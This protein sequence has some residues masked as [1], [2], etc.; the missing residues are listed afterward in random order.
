MKCTA[1][2][3]GRSTASSRSPI[4]AAAP[5]EAP[6][7]A[8][9]NLTI[10]ELEQMLGEFGTRI[11]LQG[12]I[13]NKGFVMQIVVQA[14]DNIGVVSRALTVDGQNVRMGRDFVTEM[15]ARAPAQSQKHYASAVRQL[16]EEQLDDLPISK[17]QLDA[18]LDPASMT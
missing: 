4:P 11:G 17:E 15:V 9:A 12:E 6:A 3:A 5:Q 10:V 1:E 13:I 18:A 7:G 14:N 2:P 8:E 16:C